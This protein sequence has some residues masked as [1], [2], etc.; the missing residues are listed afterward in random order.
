MLTDG[1]IQA[2]LCG[3]AVATKA[4][5]EGVGKRLVKEAF[6]RSGAQRIDLLATDA[7]EEFYGSFEHR[8]MPGYRIYPRDDFSGG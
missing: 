1:E 2:Y 8:T 4:R 7:S 3:L 6:V 5:R